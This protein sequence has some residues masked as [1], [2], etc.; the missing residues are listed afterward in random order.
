MYDPNI[1]KHYYNDGAQWEASAARLLLRAC[2]Q[3]GSRDLNPDPEVEGVA[4]GL[5]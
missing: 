1:P 3:G 2:V 4:E 5:K